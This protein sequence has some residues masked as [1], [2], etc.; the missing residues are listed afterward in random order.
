MGYC[1]YCVSSDYFS[2]TFKVIPKRIWERFEIATKLQFGT[3]IALKKI[4]CSRKALSKSIVVANMATLPILGGT[5]TYAWRH[6]VCK[7]NA[8]SLFHTE[9]DMPNC[10][11]KYCAA[12]SNG[13]ISRM[14][15]S[16][17]PE[18][19]VHVSVCRKMVRL[20]KHFPYEVYDTDVF[21]VGY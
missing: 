20:L 3:P 9:P 19:P 6:M 8:G 2:E 13:E 18:V 15:H 4:L 16:S 5:T 11:G 10:R 21:A 7:P 1:Q 17:N 12:A 14:N